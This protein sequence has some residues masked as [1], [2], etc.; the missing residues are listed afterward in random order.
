MRPYNYLPTQPGRGATVVERDGVSLGV[1]NLSGIVHL[2]AGSPPL[3]AIDA[4]L[5]EVARRRPRSSSTCTRR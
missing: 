3:V 4:A 1:V 5:R 2:Q